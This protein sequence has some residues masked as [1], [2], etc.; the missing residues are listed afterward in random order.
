MKSVSPAFG[1]PAETAGNS[2]SPSAK[3]TPQH[4]ASGA[5]PAAIRLP[6]NFFEQA[7]IRILHGQ[8]DGVY[9]VHLFL[10]LLSLAAKSNR[11]GALMLTDDLP[12]DKAILLSLIPLDA[13]QLQ[14]ALKCRSKSTSD[15][16]LIYPRK[17]LPQ[18]RGSGTGNEG[19]DGAFASNAFVHTNLTI[20]MPHADA[21]HRWLGP[22]PNPR[23]ARF[24][25]VNRTSLHHRAL[26]APMMLSPRS[27]GTIQ[28]EKAQAPI[29][30]DARQSKI[31]LV[32]K[33]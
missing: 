1:N 2:C 13:K 30:P 10:M 31:Y 3:Q 28:N 29:T 15:A 5:I 6:L 21:P 22:C 17:A 24:P 26:R 7:T 25:S 23:S 19:N 32:L 9:T 8:K 14:P 27:R 16:R 18:I 11:D 12:Y 20:S 4:T 33:R